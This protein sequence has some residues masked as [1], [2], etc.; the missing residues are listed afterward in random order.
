MCG[1]F[2]IATS[3]GHIDPDQFNIP[4]ETPVL[5]HRGPDD[6]GYFLNPQVYLSHRRLSIIDLHTGKQPIYSADSSKCIV[7]NGEVYN[8]MELRACLESKG[9]RFITNTDTEVILTAYEEWGNECVHKLRGMFA[10][11]V[12]DSKTRSLFIARDR[13]GIKPLFYA[14]YNGIFYFASEMKAILQFHHFPREIDSDGLASYFMLSYIPAPLTIFKHIR[15]LPAGHTLSW[16]DGSITLNKYWDIFFVPDRTKSVDYFVEGYTALLEEAVKLRMISDVPLGA[17]LSGGIDSG[18]VV[19]MMS[20]STTEPLRSFCI[21]FGGHIGGYLDERHYARQV[22]SKYGTLH[23]E[24]I[25]MPQ[26]DA[27]MD[28]IVRSFDEPFADHST[29]PSFYLCQSTRRKVTVALSGLG[30]DELF[31]GYERYLGVKLSSLYNRI[32][33]LIRD[34]LIQNIVMKIPERAD[35]HYTVNHIK[36]FVRSA[37]APPDHRYFGFI[38]MLAKKGITS[39]FSDPESLN[40]HF[41]NCQEA[42][43]ALFNSDNASEPLDRAFYSDIKTYVPE[44]ILA[45]ADRMS[46]RHSLEVRVPFLDHKLLEF[47][48]TIPSEMKIRRFNKKYIL[49]KGAQRI[50]PTSVI[51]H[52]KQGFVAPMT[53]WLQTDLKP[54]VL[55]VLSRQHLASHDLFNYNAVTSLLTDHFNRVEIHDKLIWSLVIFQTWYNLY[56]DSTN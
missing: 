31:G 55:G 43:A 18:T 49:K 56:I 50:L 4:N 51:T 30:G 46:M 32:P 24:D 23:T 8:F 47:C 21:A 9:Y 54:Y 12:W 14:Y 39:I 35:G 37:A 53:R 28:D 10:F 16:R 45:C 34:H 42:Y 20:K 52:R 25:V 26:L 13:L 5:Y 41:S 3:S 15:K 7:F 1:I 22:V 48:A 6:H 17:F 40:T 29:I 44:D 33:P 38:S 27:I 19:A 11:A 36:R 2:G